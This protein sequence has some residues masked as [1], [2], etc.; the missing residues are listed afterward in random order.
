MRIMNH[1]V[2]KRMGLR[3]SDASIAVEYENE[4]LLDIID[5]KP[6]SAG[7][8]EP[9]EFCEILIQL[10]PEF[11]SNQLSRMVKTKY[12]K[13]RFYLSH[14]NPLF[15]PFFGD[16]EKT[17][18]FFFSNETSCISLCEGKKGMTTN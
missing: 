2:V 3:F 6:F 12:W 7:S 13:I 17:I 14:F 15:L 16:Q 10:Y 4:N 18:H 1:K 5:L 9:D 8:K 11:S